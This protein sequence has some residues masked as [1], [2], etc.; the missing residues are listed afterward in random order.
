MD[1]TIMRRF[2]R[3]LI[4]EDGNSVSER[5]SVYVEGDLSGDVATVGEI[6]RNVRISAYDRE[7]AGFIYTDRIRLLKIQDGYEIISI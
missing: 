6:I 1:D 5:M 2:V 7:R 3:R 4:I